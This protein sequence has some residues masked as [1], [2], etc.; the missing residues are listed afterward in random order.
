M[1]VNS[2]KLQTLFIPR[3]CAAQNTDVGRKSLN[4]MRSPGSSSPVGIALYTVFQTN[5]GLTMT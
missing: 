1:S 5:V 4:H 3:E 2:S